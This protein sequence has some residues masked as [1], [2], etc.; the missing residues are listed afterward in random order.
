MNSSFLKKHV[1]LNESPVSLQVLWHCQNLFAAKL[2]FQGQ[3]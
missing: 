2:Y 1:G 3:R